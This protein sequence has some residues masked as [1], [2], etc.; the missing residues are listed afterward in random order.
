MSTPFILRTIQVQRAGVRTAD[1]HV[2]RCYNC[3]T[4]AESDEYLEFM[5]PVGSK[6]QIVGVGR[7][8]VVAHLP[9]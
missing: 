4:Q 8:E 3:T 1:K 5:Y 2:V 9:A 6:H 7:V